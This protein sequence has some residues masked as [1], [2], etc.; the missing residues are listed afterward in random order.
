MAV[1]SRLTE[2]H[3]LIAF[4]RLPKSRIW[5]VVVESMV[6]WQ[7]ENVPETFIQEEILMKGL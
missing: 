7:R 6:I 1:K 5:R 2:H 3:F 4:E